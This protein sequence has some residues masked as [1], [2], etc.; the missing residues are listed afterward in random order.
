MSPTASA[1]ASL[2]T[3]AGMFHVSWAL[4]RRRYRLETPCD[5]RRI[6][7]TPDGWDLAL[8][9]YRPRDLVPGREPVVLCHGMLS[10]RFNV[11]LDEGSSLARYLRGRGLDA[12]VLELRGHG[13]SH[14][15]GSGRLRPF[16]WT[17]DDYIHRDL[18]AAVD[19]VRGATGAERVHWFGHS[20]G[21]MVL[22]GA[23]AA[24]TAEGR[25]RSAALSDAPASF[26]R[27]RRRARIGRLYGRLI[28]AVPP[29][30]VLPW[31]GPAAWTVPALLG[32]RY[33][34]SERRLVMTILANAIISWGS[35][36]ALLHFCDL[37]ESGR[38]RSSDGALDYEEGP[39]RIRF[40]LM[41]LSAARKLM[42]EQAV[43]CGYE[44]AAASEKRYVRF[45]RAEGCARDYTHSNLLVSPTSQHE[46]YPV[47]A[48]WL[49]GHS[50][51]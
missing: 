31:L 49:L 36:R 9:R 5:E 22:Y 35:S 40:P 24:G 19:H 7:R 16:D 18:P 43:R 45:G 11:D 41:V 44:R 1:A 13:G 37:L 27:L 48:D 17:L 47:V 29:A 20:M 21:G 14:R 15:T 2:A 23:C 51:A 34:V 46:V 26:E 12:W 38:F 3:L 10:N 4:L 28:P 30:L 8:Y 32:R 42:D 33:G 50:S 25:I 39:G 6:A